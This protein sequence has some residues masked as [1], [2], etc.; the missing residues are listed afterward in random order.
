M[1]EC[2]AALLRQLSAMDAELGSGKISVSKI[3]TEKT[4]PFL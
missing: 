2:L 3:E 4:N 1:L